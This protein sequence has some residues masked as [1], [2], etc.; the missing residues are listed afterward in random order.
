MRAYPPQPDRTMWSISR[1]A[2]GGKRPV[3]SSPRGSLAALLAGIGFTVS[4]A[5][6]VLLGMPRCARVVTPQGGPKDTLHPQVVRCAPPNGIT[7]FKGGEVRITFNEYVKLKDPQKSIIVSPPLKVPI[8]R[9]KSLVIRLDDSL[10]PHTTYSIRWGNAVVDLTEGNPVQGL[11]YVFS[12]GPAIDSCRLSGIVRDAFLH[13]PLESAHVML[14][15]EADDSLAA[16]RKPDFVARTDAS[17]RFEFTHLPKGQFTLAALKEANGNLLYDDAAKET[18]A[19]HSQPIEGTCE[20]RMSST[21]AQIQDSLHAPD[22]MAAGPITLNGFMQRWGR[23]RLLRKL[24][25]AREQL[26]FVFSHLND[27]SVTASLCGQPSA[28]LVAERAGDTVSFW[29]MDSTVAAIDSLAMCLRHASTDSLGSVAMR[30]DTVHLVYTP[31]KAGKGG[32][33]G[34]QPKPSAKSSTEERAH[35]GFRMTLTYRSSAEFVPGDTLTLSSP[36]VPTT[37]DTTRIAVIDL[38]DSSR[39]PYRI[40]RYPRMPRRL[41]IIPTLA[42]HEQY[43]LEV[44]PGAFHDLIGSTND[45]LRQ[46][47]KLADASKHCIVR[48]VLSHAPDRCLVQLTGTGNERRTQYQAARAA[49]QDTVTLHYVKPGTYGIRLVED[50][51]GNGQWDAGDYFAKVQPEPVRYFSGEKGQNELKVRQNWEYSLKVDYSKLAE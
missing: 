49:G 35:K 40:V 4:L 7:Q 34:G 6:S 38:T 41:S 47:I 22:K 30:T 27:D 25:P 33:K 36:R 43:R 28:R 10:Q 19:F 45:T 44:L 8:I 18:I 23:Q 48:I 42:T 13:K 2:M 21:S 39:R 26:A 11:E 51:N 1:F 5:V 9:G 32:A 3:V 12:T 17:G 29:I 16:K 37:I 15:R 31:A 20:S 24:R 14:Y 50:V 46:D